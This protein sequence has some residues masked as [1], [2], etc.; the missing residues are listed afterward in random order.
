M[1]EVR[2]DAARDTLTLSVGDASRMI[3]AAVDD[4]DQCLAF[5]PPADVRGLVESLRASLTPTT[6]VP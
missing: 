6:S 2:G 4:L 5:D 1:R 3:V